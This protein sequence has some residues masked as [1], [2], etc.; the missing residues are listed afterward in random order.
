ML[1]PGSWQFL[2]TLEALIHLV[3]HTGGSSE[4]II[5]MLEKQLASV[6]AIHTGAPRMRALML[7]NLARY[8]SD[9]DKHD[10]AG[11][12]L[13]KSA[14]ISDLLL[15]DGDS[16]VSLFEFQ[17]VAFNLGFSLGEQRRYQEAA[18]F[19][20]RSLEMQEQFLGEN[21]PDLIKGL[22]HLM[23]CLHNTGRHAEEE[24]IRARLSTL[25]LDSDYDPH[26][27]HGP[28]CPWY[29]SRCPAPE[30][31]ALSASAQ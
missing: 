4:G 25:Q 3:T 2:E 7:Q 16:S 10:R 27:S 17:S 12:L 18:H 19:F 20:R 28:S 13:A 5:E 21:H 23:R 26:Q 9:L 15:Q 1:G 6:E 24:P 30:S 22:D 14:E 29:L 8:F 31:Q 11:D